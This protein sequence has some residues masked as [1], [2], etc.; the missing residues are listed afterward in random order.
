MLRSVNTT[1]TITPKG[2]G[3]KHT[4]SARVTSA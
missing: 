1:A 4:T 3:A 2:S